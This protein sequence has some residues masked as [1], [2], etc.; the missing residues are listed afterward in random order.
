VRAIEKVGRRLC[1]AG[2]SED[3]ENGENME[4]EI[5]SLYLSNSPLHTHPTR[6]YAPLANYL[7]IPRLHRHYHFRRIQDYLFE[8]VSPIFRAAATVLGKTTA[9]DARSGNR[10]SYELAQVGRPWRERPRLP[11]LI[12]WPPTEKSE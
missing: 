12:R 3:V 9:G 4:E 6:V 10:D 11:N 2:L 7:R 5:T 1:W 8:D